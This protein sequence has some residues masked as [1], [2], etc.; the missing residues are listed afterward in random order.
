MQST[1]LEE[2]KAALWEQSQHP[3]TRVTMGSRTGDGSQKK[4]EG[5]PTRSASRVETAFA[6]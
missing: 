2:I 5:M 4:Q 3:C 6:L 1:D